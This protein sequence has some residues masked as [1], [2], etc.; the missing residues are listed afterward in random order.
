M[1]LTDLQTF[2]EEFNTAHPVFQWIFR[3][4]RNWIGISDLIPSM[5]EHL[6]ST[7]YL[8]A[9]T[10][11]SNSRDVSDGGDDDDNSSYSATFRELF[12]ITAHEIAKTLDTSL[13]N[14]GCLYEDVLTTG[15]VMNRAIWTSNHANKTIL[16]ADVVTAP[17]DVEAG[18]VNPILFGR[19]QMLVLTRKVD[20][21]E[22]RRLKNLGYSFANVQKVSDHL[23]RSLQ[24]P[25]NDLEN[26]VDRLQAFNDRQLSMPE[27]GTYLASFLVQPRAG[28][29]GMDVVVPRA[30]P[31]QLPMVKL[32]DEELDSRQMSI[33]LAFDG[34]TLDNCLSHIY[35][36]SAA[37]P[38]SPEDGLFLEKFCNR[39]VDLVRDCPEQALGQ[40]TFSALQVD[41]VHDTL[42]STE[43]HQ[44]TVFAFCGIRDFHLQ[45]LQSPT[46]KMIPMSFFQTYLRSQAGCVD[47]AIL[48]QKNHK[49]FSSLQRTP[50]VQK[51][52]PSKAGGMW[53]GLRSKKR[54]ASTDISW[55]ADTCSEKGLVS[56]SQSLAEPSTHA[57]GGIMVTSTQDIHVNES[58]DSTDLEMCELGVKAK[59]G[60]QETEQQTLADRLMATTTAFRDPCTTRPLPRN[61]YYGGRW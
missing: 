3:V 49:E 35:E 17:S 13:P 16:A 29:R 54:S 19:G 8:Q 14:L 44:A 38:A 21:A 41:M 2:D 4:S 7:G 33:L 27:K 20:K 1:Q 37:A 31:H 34:L 47:H 60:I 12:C 9:P 52:A 11:G 5:R 10:H 26:L 40:A 15:T 45:S 48:A 39:I 24:I 46:L 36:L 61:T 43:S 53:R 56:V 25:R 23:A 51:P 32:S 50:T 55:K 59:I 57:W 58:K 28:M 6:Q 30:T 42:A 22:A 18:V